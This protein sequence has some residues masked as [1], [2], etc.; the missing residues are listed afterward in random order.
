MCCYRMASCWRRTS[1]TETPAATRCSST[2]TDRQSSPRFH[3]DKNDPPTLILHGMIDQIAP[4]AQADGLAAHLKELKI[5]HSY[6]R[7]DGWPHTMDL[8]KP[9]ND[10]CLAMMDRFFRQT[11]P[12][13]LKEKFI[14]GVYKMLFIL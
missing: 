6:G 9:V 11:H 14:L 5:P 7:L 4:I 13:A 1:N 3:L 2:C 12:A 10:Y 8:A